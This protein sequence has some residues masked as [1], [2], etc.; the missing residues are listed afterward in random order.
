MTKEIA[1]T[2]GGD[3]LT[4]YQ[5]EKFHILTPLTRM[6]GMPAGIVPSWRE[7]KIEEADCYPI[8]RELLGLGGV[9]IQR[10]AQVAGV[11]TI[12]VRRTDDRRHPYC[13]EYTATVSVIDFDGS[14]RVKTASSAIDLRSDAAEGIPGG[15][16][17]AMLRDIEKQEARSGRKI[18]VTDRLTQ[19]RKFIHRICATQAELRAIAKIT[20]LKRAYKRDELARPFAVPKI[21]LDPS[22]PDAKRVMLAAASGAQTALYGP[23]EQMEKRAE[24]ATVERPSEEP[25]VDA[26]PTDDEPSQKAQTLLADAW[27]YSKQNKIGKTEFKRIFDAMG[28]ERGEI[29]VNDMKAF[30][31][32]L[33]IRAE[34]LSGDDG[35]P[36]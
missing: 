23:P 19:A 11:S 21:S 20:G 31:D 5:E 28:K 10:I 9:A 7:V 16:L 6:T 36:V 25:T 30:T 26:P 1:T 18:D 29:T 12:D 3:A 34:E 24:G 15:D 32:K 33:S 13:S 22:D 27:E 35:I 4:K 14:R 2:T 8:T 17:A